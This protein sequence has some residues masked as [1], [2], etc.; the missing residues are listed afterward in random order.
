[1]SQK[2][3]EYEDLKERMRNLKLLETSISVLGWDMRTYMPKG[4]AQQRGSQLGYLTNI[5]HDFLVSEK[6]RNLLKKCSNNPQIMENEIYRRNIE[7]WQRAYDRE[8]KLPA[9][10]V[11]ELTKQETKTEMLWEKAKG[12]SDYAMV[13]PELKA[14]FELLKKKANLLDPDKDMYDVMLDLYEKNVNQEIIN[15]F[16]GKLKTG[17]IDIVKK[18]ANSEIK[19]NPELIRIKTPIE[20]QR[21]I[22][23]FIMEYLKMDPMRS[24]VDETEHPFTT[25]Y[26]DDV[27]ITTHYL[28]DDPMGS[29][30]SVFHEAGHAT[31]ELNLPKEHLWTAIGESVSMG[32]HES[33]SRFFENLIGKSPEFLKFVYPK[34]NEYIP[35]LNKIN[36]Q[37]FILAVNS[38][39][40]SKIRIYADEVTY[41]L[42]IIIRYEL[43]RDLFGGKITFEELPHVWNEKMESYLSQKIERDA[44]GVLQ[45]IHWYGGAFGYFPDYAL[46]NIYN[47]QMLWAMKKDIPN[48]DELLLNGEPSKILDW[49]KDKV[50]SL[51]FLYDPVDLVQHISG[52]EPDAKYFL[53]YLYDK[54]GK[55]YNFK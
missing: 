32:I 15:K 14:L 4:A 34:L 42:H 30:Y 22:S 10:L 23:K 51:G 24:R 13:M 21:K 35:G 6:T 55:L 45:D 25:G 31:Y 47:G 54:F 44:E 48:Y 12:K 8:S 11:K 29:F 43:E 1:M 20:N 26:A 33:Q 52:V 38:V 5:Y 18:V 50:H 9:D 28:E 39:I 53:D 41:N 19:A 2:I 7:L 16:F 40:P 3:A 27:R 49:L 46:G 36:L 37:D 17:V